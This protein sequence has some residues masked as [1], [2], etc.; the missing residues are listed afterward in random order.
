MRLGRRLPTLAA[1]AFVAIWSTG[2]IVARGIAPLADPN[3]FLAV[4]FALCGALFVA[5]ALWRGSRGR[6]GRA[7][8]S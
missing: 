5:F 1:V 7:R 3:L 4:R 2:F 8:R 6:A